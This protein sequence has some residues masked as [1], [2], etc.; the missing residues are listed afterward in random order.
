MRLTWKDALA[1]VVAGV[2]VAVYVAFTQGADVPIIDNARGATAVILLLGIAGGCALSAAP[3]ESERKG[4][5]V[6]VASTLG[7]IALIAGVL[8]LITA[9]EMAVGVL[10]YSAIALWFIATVRHALAPSKTEALR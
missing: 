7:G 3:E 10:F 5:Y 2:N 4:T 1:T 8:G 9:S 6:V